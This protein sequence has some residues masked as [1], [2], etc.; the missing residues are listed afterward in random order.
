MSKDTTFILSSDISKNA[1]KHLIKSSHPH[2]ASRFKHRF[3]SDNENPVT[4]EIVPGDTQEE[5]S[6]MLETLES[7]I[8][9]ELRRENG[10]ALRVLKDYINAFK[11]E[12]SGTTSSIAG[13]VEGMRAYLITNK[14][15]WLVSTRETDTSVMYLPLSITLER[16]EG[17]G[18]REDHEYAEL[19][20]AFNTHSGFRTATRNVTAQSYGLTLSSRTIKGWLH[21]LELRFATDEDMETYEKQNARFKKFLSEPNL[22]VWVSGPA[23]ETRSA[24]WW[25]ATKDRNL[26]LKGKPSKAVLDLS[27]AGEF[28]KDLD[29]ATQEVNS[30][31]TRL[32]RTIKNARWLRHEKEDGRED[33]RVPLHPLLPVFSLA[34]HTDYWVNVANMSTYKY[35]EAIQD[36]LVLPPNQVKLL[37]ALIKD[38]DLFLDTDDGASSRSRVM[39]DKAQSR[40]I[41]LK[42]PPGV[43]KT[44]TS[45]VYAER[46]KRPL[47]EVACGQLGSDPEELEDRLAKILNRSIVMD[48]PLVLNEA[49]VFIKARGDDLT[50]NAIISVFLRL[51]E[52]HTGLVFLTTNRPNDID[53]AMLS[54]CIAVIDCQAPGEAER[55]RLWEVLSKEFDRAMPSHLA[56]RA[57]KLF[58]KAV[59]RDIQNLLI[60]TRRVCSAHGEKISLSAL[61][62]NAMFRNVQVDPD[63]SAEV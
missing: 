34:L 54:R 18:R 53:D 2:L 33:L 47:Y 52:Y 17:R 51:L 3:S 11:D 9:K 36:K 63:Q 45:E 8:P 21:H 44:L 38:L 49:D 19:K 26:T 37:D 42:G 29:D 1:V 59:G 41:L 56:A 61:K 16:Y 32:V 12:G 23:V 4:V 60:L 5:A 28:A 24:N 22:Q 40:V 62:D 14:N 46:I 58:P 27:Q 43:G 10:K 55:K 15:R 13:L 57:A 31:H 30:S 48:M 35:D 6:A 39:T 25:F 50:Q 20:L 7:V